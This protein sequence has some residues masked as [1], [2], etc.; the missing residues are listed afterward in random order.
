MAGYTT[1]MTTQTQS[2]RKR[3]TS[4]ETRP[5]GSPQETHPEQR[6]QHTA[7]KQ[8][9]NQPKQYTDGRHPSPYSTYGQTAREPLLLVAPAAII[10]PHSCGGTDTV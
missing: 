2:A 8:R 1:V 3:Y 10:T 9:N 5:D 4:L 7:G 6:A